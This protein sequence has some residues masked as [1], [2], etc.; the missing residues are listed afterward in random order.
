MFILTKQ[1]NN[2]S[3]LCYTYISFEHNY[4][5]VFISCVF[6]HLF[7]QIDADATC[8]NTQYSLIEL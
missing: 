8:E 2:V 6:I 3:I 1:K 7:S 5:I 4:Q